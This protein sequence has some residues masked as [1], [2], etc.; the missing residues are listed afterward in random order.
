M[1]PLVGSL[2]S[3]LATSMDYSWPQ[4]RSL[5]C[6]VACGLWL[7]ML[8]IAACGGA[9]PGRTVVRGSALPSGSRFRCA[10]GMLLVPASRIGSAA[11]ASCAVSV[12]QGHE[13]VNTSEFC[14]DRTEV[15]VGEFLGRMAFARESADRRVSF[16][17]GGVERLRAL[18]TDCNLRRPEDQWQPV[19]CVDPEVAEAVCALR[20]ARLPTCVEWIVAAGTNG[21]PGRMPWGT[22]PL[23]GT[24]ANAYDRSAW[25]L[26]DES[27][28]P[29]ANDGFSGTAPVGSFPAGASPVG[30]L[31]MAGNVAEF[32]RY[33]RV[34]VV[35]RDGSSLEVWAY[36]F[37]GGSFLST[38]GWDYV[39]SEGSRLIDTTD[40]RSGDV[41][42]RCVS[43][44]VSSAP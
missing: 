43:D 40:M 13:S 31:D 33:R 7:L 21:E 30:A 34:R 28:V 44:A 41:G 27:A 12:A 29:L 35:R 32:V 26:A 42:F 11:A 4:A 24:R 37:M 38:G 1:G 23:D 9:T 14:V 22:A 10:R 25:T 18:G 16:P 17:P 5:E 36:R 6:I 8:G 39:L 19:N 15:T 3:N 2:R 20:G